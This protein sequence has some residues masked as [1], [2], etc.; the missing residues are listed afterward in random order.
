MAHSSERSCQK[1]L[2]STA[3][4]SGKGKMQERW[5]HLT[6][7]RTWELILYQNK[8]HEAILTT[9]HLSEA[10][11]Q[12]QFSYLKGTFQCWGS[13]SMSAPFWPAAFFTHKAEMQIK[14][15]CVFYR[16]CWG[17][18]RLFLLLAPVLLPSDSEARLQEQLMPCKLF[19]SIYNTLGIK[20]IWQLS[21]RR[22]KQ[23]FHS[24]HFLI[25]TTTTE[26]G[27]R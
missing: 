27:Q 7:M 19:P 14:L 18:P 26:I 8:S 10:P 11:K 4:P 23:M 2:Q 21:V 25:L 24:T 5:V 13:F 20:G 12:L 16:H 6:H 9:A 17:F 22:E 15:P 3:P 1:L